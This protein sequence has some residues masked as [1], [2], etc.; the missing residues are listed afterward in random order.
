M[1]K[2]S[3]LVTV[4]LLCLNSFAAHATKQHVPRIVATVNLRNQTSQITNR[5]L[6]TPRRDTTYRVSGYITAASGGDWILGVRWTDQYGDQGCGQNNPC[7]GNGSAEQFLGITVRDIA[8]APL[9]FSTTGRG[10][11]PYD[12]FLVVEEL[13]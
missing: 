8:G 7:N 4:V 2:A 1:R 12:V 5:M 6:L 3:T 13:R 9:A 11:G 10:S